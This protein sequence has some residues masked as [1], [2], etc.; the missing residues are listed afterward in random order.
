MYAYIIKRMLAAIPTIIGVVTIVFLVL[1]LIPGD[2]IDMM[3]PP[4]M[5]AA[6][7][8]DVAD[9]LRAR[10]GFDRPL[11]EQYLRYMGN[12][13]RFDLGRSLRTESPIIWD[14]NRRLPNTLQLSA[15]ALV[16]SAMFGVLLGV[17]SAIKRTTIF[18][19]ITML[20]ALFWVSMPN[21]W[22]GLL[23]M[24][25]LGLY[26]GILPA[27]GFGGPIYT[28][29]GFQ[30][31]IMPALTLGLR[32]AAVIARFSRSS[33]LDVITQDY[34]RTAR[35]KGLP[36]RVVVFKHALK[37][38]LIPVITLLALQFGSLIAGAVV[39]ETVFAWPGVGRYMINAI[40]GR[41]F[42]A[43]QASVLIVALGFVLANL[44]TDIAYAYIDPRIRYS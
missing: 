22:L 44:V 12:L 15:L 14:L 27:S 30:Y 16:F 10:Y 1:H 36:E 6:A 3:I 24:L 42:P 19:N 25:I 40:H 31:I 8:G 23:M 34:I 7:R 18:D 26:L 20:G 28:W 5:P 33:M 4:D 35:A 41:D 38:T 11:H 43:V 2:P 37:N 29:T 13:L 39:I 32:G 21:F 17:L 9:A